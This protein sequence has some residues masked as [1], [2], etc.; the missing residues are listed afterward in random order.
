[1]TERQKQEW[2]AHND[3][4]QDAYRQYRWAKKEK[5]KDSALQRIKAAIDWKP[6][7]IYCDNELA[8]LSGITRYGLDMITER[9]IGEI[10][11]I[12]KGESEYDY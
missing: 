12:A 4:L 11:K 9:C 2:I 8:A 1:M 6:F 5:E 3:L 7:I 10:D